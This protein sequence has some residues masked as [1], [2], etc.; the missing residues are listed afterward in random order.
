MLKIASMII[1]VSVLTSCGGGWPI[2]PPVIWDCQINWTKEH[3]NGGYFCETTEPKKEDREREFREFQDPRMKGGHA[4]S[5]EDFK[6]SE[7]WLKDT[8]QWVSE[9]CK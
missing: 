9:H 8:K 7:R 1:A 2:T 3:P 6:K 5:P 4:I